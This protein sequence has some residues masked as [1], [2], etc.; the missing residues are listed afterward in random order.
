MIL[1]GGRCQLPV[2][3][4]VLIFKG[5]FSFSKLLEP[6]LYHTFISSSWAKCI[7]DVGVVSSAL[8]PILNLNKKTARIYFLSYIIFIV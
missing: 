2:A 8:G 1:S 5:L 6:P 3:G 7:V 4:T